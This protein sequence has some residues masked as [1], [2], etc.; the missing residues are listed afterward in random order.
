MWTELEKKKILVFESERL[1]GIT[2]TQ[3][4]TAHLN[5]LAPGGEEGI[6]LVL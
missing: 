4:S 5:S 3:Y 6:A 1:F 2:K